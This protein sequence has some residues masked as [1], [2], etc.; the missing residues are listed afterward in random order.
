MN[1]VLHIR[2]QVFGCE[3][4]KAFADL[5]GTS[6]ASVSRWELWG[7]IPGHKQP[8]IKEA[9]AKS[10]LPWDDRWFFTAPKRT[11]GAAA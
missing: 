1:P 3:T 10:G 8:V 9:A 5:V 6:Q 4:Q 2:R 11:P 7:R